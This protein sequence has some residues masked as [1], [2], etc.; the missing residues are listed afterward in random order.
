MCGKS[1]RTWLCVCL[2]LEVECRGIP[3]VFFCVGAGWGC[4]NSLE[5]YHIF[6]ASKQ[7]IHMNEFSIEQ[8]NPIYDTIDQ[9]LKDYPHR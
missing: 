6:L 9:Q 1:V 3:R 5:K 2:C 4:R 7:D 8:N